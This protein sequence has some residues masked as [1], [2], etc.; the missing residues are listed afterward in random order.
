MSD[1]LSLIYTMGKVGSSALES[2]IPNS[3]HL[4]SLY[5]NPPNPVHWNMRNPGVMDKLNAKLKVHAKRLYFKSKS[6]IDIITVVRNP[7]DR[8]I[9]MFFQALPFWLSN[10]LS[11]YKNK[12]ESENRFEGIDV[13]FTSFINDFNH[14]Y[15]L[16]WLDDE[17]KEFSGI[18]IYKRP[19]DLDT[20][21]KIFEKG[22]YRILLL[23]FNYLPIATH[24]LEDFLQHKVTLE[25]KNTGSK[26]WYGEVYKNFKKELILPKDLK[27]ELESSKY[28]NHFGYK[29]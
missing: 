17:I 9:S 19:F 2:S 25:H 21:Y 11:G 18:D 29:I 6:H 8:N 16:T 13:L 24:I 3:Y 27:R 12:G 5:N 14:S 7:L 28:S 10:S 20:G 4:H 15:P 1:K 22:K 23:E 26:K